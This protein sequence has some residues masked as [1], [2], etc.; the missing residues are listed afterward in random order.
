MQ[1]ISD[2]IEFET[3]NAATVV[4]LRKICSKWQVLL[5]QNEVKNWLRSTEKSTVIMR[6][7]GEW[8]FP[9][10]VVEDADS[11]FRDTAIRELQEEFI[12]VGINSSNCTLHL[13]NCKLTRPI[14]GKSFHMHNFVAFQEENDW[15]NDGCLD[16]NINRNLVAKK[17]KFL[18]AVE[19]GEF[20]T[21]SEDEK[22]AVS[23][24]VHRVAWIDIDS[25]I[26]H[27]SAAESTPSCI[28]DDFQREEFAKYSV[29]CRDP[30]YQSSAVL[31]DI[32]GLGTKLAII[33]HA[34]KNAKH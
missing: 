3:M 26:E 33:A 18:A 28:E 2:Q 10:G 8:K 20:W 5:G 13:L 17:N 12:G 29:L 9:G 22:S 19:S 21:L 4:C 34:S 32:L 25:A 11:T 16:E 15:L 24:E 27:M 23:P 14:Q 7:P 6:Y 30:M 1:K 31:R